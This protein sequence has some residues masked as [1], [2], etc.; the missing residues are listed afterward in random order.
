MDFSCSLSVFYSVNSFLV[1]WWVQL[2]AFTRW[3]LSQSPGLISPHSLKV[4]DYWEQNPKEKRTSWAWKLRTDFDSFV[5]TISPKLSHSL[6]AGDQLL[7]R[8]V[9][10][11]KLCGPVHHHPV[12]VLAAPLPCTSADCTPLQLLLILTSFCWSIVPVSCCVICPSVLNVTICPQKNVLYKILI[13]PF[14][15]INPT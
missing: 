7:N 12:P 8:Q 15:I 3:H 11:A 13:M 1:R 10:A 9:S 6:S 14:C 5:T 4:V 2:P